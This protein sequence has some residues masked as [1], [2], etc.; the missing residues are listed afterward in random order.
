MITPDD[1]EPRLAVLGDLHEACL[2]ARMSLVQVSH[3]HH[4]EMTGVR[5]AHDPRIQTVTSAD[6]AETVTVR[7]GAIGLDAQVELTDPRLDHSSQAVL[8][9]AFRNGRA[10]DDFEQRQTIRSH[11]SPRKGI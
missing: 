8:V 2:R 7:A 3:A 5:T 4:I 6:D 11:H 9:H 1:P 10:E